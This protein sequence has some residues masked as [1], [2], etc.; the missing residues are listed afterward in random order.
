MKYPTLFFT[1][2]C[3]ALRAFADMPAQERKRAAHRDA[4]KGL[5]EQAQL[6]AQEMTKRDVV[7]EGLRDAMSSKSIELVMTFPP[8]PY[9]TYELRR[10]N[11]TWDFW[12]RDV[13]PEMVWALSSRGLSLNAAAVPLL[14]RAFRKK[15]DRMREWALE[16]IAKHPGDFSWVS[17]MTGHNLASRPDFAGDLL[18]A[19]CRE[20]PDVAGKAL[21]RA[22]EFWDG[23]RTALLLNAGAR[24]PEDASP[25]SVKWLDTLSHHRKLSVMRSSTHA[26]AADKTALR[27]ARQLFKE[28]AS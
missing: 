6:V 21:A 16:Y 25:K 3:K 19:A 18:D 8:A 15:D 17:A 1:T 5:L 2:L 14:A 23:V 11:N 26:F 9:G 4:G 27:A 13:D 10:N 22:I 7:A 20:V 28:R 24:L 12:A